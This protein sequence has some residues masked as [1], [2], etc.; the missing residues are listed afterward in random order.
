[1][2]A[3][4]TLP[5][6]LAPPAASATGTD[7][8]IPA[9]VTIDPCRPSSAEFTADDLDLVAEDGR[10][11]ELIG[12]MLVVS[13]SPRSIHQVVVVDLLL[14]LVQARPLGSQVLVGPFDVRVDERTKLQPDVLVMRPEQVGE[15]FT[16]AP[17]PLVVEVISPGSRAYDL[18]TKTLIYA[19]FGVPSHWVVDPVTPSVTVFRLEGDAYVEGTVAVGAEL[20]RATAPFEVSFTPDELVR[21]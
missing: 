3:P 16:D 9:A 15:T 14:R 17:P 4:V 8:V 19:A 2:S 10:R 20:V 11:W 7:L 1:M 21:P 6:T 12:G 13:P 5:V 18:G